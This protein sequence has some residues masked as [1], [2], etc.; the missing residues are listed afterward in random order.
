MEKSVLNPTEQQWV[1]AL[2]DFIKKNELAFNSLFFNKYFNSPVA[3]G[4]REKVCSAL[5]LL[6]KTDINTFRL[7]ESV[8][9]SVFVDDRILITESASEPELALV[10]K[11]QLLVWKKVDPDNFKRG[12]KQ[13]K[14]T[15]YI[16]KK[17]EK[18]TYGSHAIFSNVDMA[19]FYRNKKAHAGGVPKA[20]LVTSFLIAIFTL[21]AIMEAILVE[22]NGI[23]ISVKGCDEATLKITHNEEIEKENIELLDG[24]TLS[25][26]L[27]PNRYELTIS[28]EGQPVTKFEKTIEAGKYE[29]VDIDFAAESIKKE[30]KMGMNYIENITPEYD[31]AFRHFQKAYESRPSS[32]SLSLLADSLAQTKD[33]DKQ[34]QAF[35]MFQKSMTDYDKKSPLASYWLSV[36]YCY[37]IGGCEQS[38]EKSKRFLNQ[39]REDLKSVSM[40]E[41]NYL[42]KHFHEWMKKHE[43]NIHSQPK[44]RD[45]MYK[46]RN[47]NT[48]MG[49]FLIFLVFISVFSVWCPQS[50]IVLTI[51]CIFVGGLGTLAYSQPKDIFVW[52][53]EEIKNWF[54]HQQSIAIRECEAEF[55]SRQLKVPFYTKFTPWSQLFVTLQWILYPL[56]IFEIFNWAIPC[57]VRWTGSNVNIL[58]LLSKFSSHMSVVWLNVSIVIIVASITMALY[59]YFSKPRHLLSVP[60]MRYEVSKSNHRYIRD[61]FR[62]ALILSF[63][64]VIIA[65]IIALLLDWDTAVISMKSFWPIWSNHS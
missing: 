62:R 51:A 45:F 47:G 18:I 37:G 10:E 65:P 56:G 43:Y 60:F 44:L 63:G 61:W 42:P 20:K 14:V 35:E 24:E 15:R 11:F 23:T 19:R 31:M 32:F 54:P 17:A 58:V 25:I 8:I 30:V 22:K 6:L 5:V 29:I 52:L 12:V 1:V 57:F 2:A 7:F 34:K 21:T 53:N 41:E 3:T 13:A 40:E 9:E 16:K 64:A 59:Q 4:N 38:L 46:L 55:S 27:K 50:W 39:G 26:Y 49:L 36:F 48:I 28:A 33:P